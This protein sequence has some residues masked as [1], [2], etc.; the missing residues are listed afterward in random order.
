MVFC[1][2]YVEDWNGQ[3]AT[4][5]QDDVEQTGHVITFHHVIALV[6]AQEAL[7]AEHLSQARARS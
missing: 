6:N 5:I 4:L 1:A 3:G 7:R 2:A